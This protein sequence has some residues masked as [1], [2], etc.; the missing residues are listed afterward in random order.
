MLLHFKHDGMEYVK[1]E[2]PDVFCCQETK[3]DKLKIPIKAE[4]K[5]Y[6]SYWLS[7]DKDGYSGVGLLSKIKPISVTFGISMLKNFESL[8]FFL[9]CLIDEWFF[10]TIKNS[11]LKVV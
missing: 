4:L 9:K 1:S 5:G 11:T 7:G 8:G 3:C 6:T 2:A 10:K